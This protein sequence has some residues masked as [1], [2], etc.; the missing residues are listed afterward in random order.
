MLIKER[1]AFIKGLLLMVTF[2]VV[3]AFI[4][5]PLF[6]EGNQPRENALQAA[7]KLFNSISKG[8]T[9]YM[10]DL[11]KKIAPYKGK[12]LHRD[13]QAQGRSDDSRCLETSYRGRGPGKG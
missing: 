11:S 12:S 3:L 4:F 5:T 7:D 10:A 1:R 6:G 8:S 9:N 13:H 2:F